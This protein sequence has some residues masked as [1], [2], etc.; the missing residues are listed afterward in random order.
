MTKNTLFDIAN[1]LKLWIQNQDT[2]YCLAILVE[3]H[4]ACAIYKLAQS[5][6]LFICN[7]LFVVGRSIVFLIIWEVI[8]T[9]NIV[10]SKMITWS[11]G[12]KMDVVIKL[13]KFFYN[14]PSIE[15]AI[16]GTNF[17]IAKPIGPFSED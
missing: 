3:R 12:P 10:F 16:H 13:F 7:E 4:V 15:G 8:I 17:A 2:K 11:F 9:S 6:N 5:I 14:L 1:Q